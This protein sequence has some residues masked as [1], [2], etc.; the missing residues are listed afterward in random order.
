M[1]LRTANETAELMLP[2]LLDDLKAKPGEDLLVIVNGAGATTLM[3]L[4]I[5]FRR[6]HQIAG[7]KGIRVAR[8]KVGEFITTQ[9]QGGLQLLIARMDAELLRL[10]DAPCNAPYFV[11]R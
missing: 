5:L 4:F 2:M 10:W 3:E 1:K 6:V 7:E 11:V 8:S 9:E